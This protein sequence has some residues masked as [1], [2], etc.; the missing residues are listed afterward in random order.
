M[1]HLYKWIIMDIGGGLSIAQFEYPRVTLPFPP[2]CGYTNHGY[3]QPCP[4][5]L[6]ICMR[7]CHHGSPLIKRL[8]DSLTQNLQKIHEHQ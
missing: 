5:P 6:V 1:G 3:E 4:L 2:R 7:N 8:L